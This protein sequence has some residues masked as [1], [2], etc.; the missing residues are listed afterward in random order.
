MNA[1]LWTGTGSNGN[2]ISGIGFA[3]D[4]VWV[5]NRSGTY[6]HVLFDRVRGDN[7]HIES[8]N[9][10]A[11][12]NEAYTLAFGSDGYSVGTNTL[13]NSGSNIVGW[14]W[15]ANGAGSANTDGT[16]TSTVSANTTAGMSI[17]T[18]SGTGSNASIGHGLGGVDCMIIKNTNSSRDF[19]FW[20][21]TMVYNTRLSI[22]TTSAF[23]TGTD[24]MTALPDA[25]KINM[26]VSTQNNGSSQN[27]VGYFF[28][29][30]T[31]YSKFGSYV[32]NGN[33]NGA[34]I[35]TGFKPAFFMAKRTSASGDPW[36]LIDNK[37]NT[38]NALSNTLTP[39][40]S[41]AENTGTDRADFLSNGIK[42]KTTS[43]A[44]NGSGSSYI[45]M[46]FADAPLVGTNNVPANAR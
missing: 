33:A 8:N 29:E 1:K 17:A 28:Q 26:A 32:G 5:K 38:F 30:K 4:L 16:I 19:Y 45:Y 23:T 43:D 40:D 13:N 25:T 9:T 21:K 42:I 35:Y 31:G 44:W 37:R 6:D 39:S 20:N 46:A 10:S 12:E 24:N 34:F 14:N 7:K 18:W 2:A 27:Y 41:N 11:E 22:N 3:P 36:V 15:K